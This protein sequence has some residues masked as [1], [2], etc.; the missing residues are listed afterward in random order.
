VTREGGEPVEILFIGSDATAERLSTAAGQEAAFTVRHHPP[1]AGE[2]TDAALD[3]LVVAG[4]ADPNWESIRRLTE[5]V[6]L[7]GGV[8]DLPGEPAVDL[9]PV[10]LGEAVGGAWGHVETK[11]AELRVASTAEIRAHRSWLVRLFENL[12]RNA[13]EHAGPAAL[14]EVGMLDSDSGDG[15]YVADDGRGIPPD[16]QGLLFDDG[17]STTVDGAG[18]GLRIVHEIAK[19]H[20]WS[21][22]IDD[23]I[24]GGARFEFSSVAFASDHRR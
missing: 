4:G 9:S 11:S 23:G 12:F 7:Y 14:V 21:V 19:V 20:G 5:P 16:R 17:F 3:C 6:V 1:D 8:G 2:V 24:D 15:F 22:G 13:V 18:L 10:G